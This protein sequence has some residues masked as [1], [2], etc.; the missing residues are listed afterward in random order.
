MDYTIDFMYN[1]AAL[2]AD[3]WGDVNAP[4]AIL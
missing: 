4:S 3:V 1:P 2:D